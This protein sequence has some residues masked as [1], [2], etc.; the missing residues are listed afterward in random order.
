MRI[1]FIAF[2]KAVKQHIRDITPF[3]LQVLS[4]IIIIIILGTTLRGNFSTNY[5]IKPRNIA[6]VNEDRGKSSK[7]F[8]SSLSN[9][10]FFAN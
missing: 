9:H 10:S 7:K 3:I 1:F 2:S 6:V 8:I 4:T 5:V